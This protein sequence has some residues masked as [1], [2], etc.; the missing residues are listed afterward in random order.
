MEYFQKQINLLDVLISKNYNESSL[1]TGL[2]TKSTDTYLYLH[3][4]SCHRSIYKYSIPYGQAI[5][6]KPIS[7]N[8]FDLQRKL[9]HLESRMTDRGFKSEIM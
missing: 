3:A 5:C 6:M 9:L 8:E 2:V 1:V 7:S 4:T